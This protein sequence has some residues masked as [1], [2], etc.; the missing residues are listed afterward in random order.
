LKPELRE[1]ARAAPVPRIRDDEAAA[2]VQ[3]V[4]SFDAIGELSHPNSL[5]QNVTG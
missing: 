2:F 3:F 5:N 4:K 1:D